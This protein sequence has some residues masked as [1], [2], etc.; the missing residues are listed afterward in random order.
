MNLTMIRSTGQNGY[1]R[2][3]AAGLIN[4]IGARFSQVAMLSLVLKLTGSGMAV[5]L[6][7]GLSLLPNLLFAPLGGFLGGRLSRRRILIATDLAR[8][9]FALS[10]LL[11]DGKGMLWLLYAGSFMLA[12]GEAVYAPVRKSAI[13]LLARPGTLQRVNAMEQLMTGC[14]LVLGALTGGLV[15]YWF[16]PDTAFVLNALSF[17]G[18]AVI[19]SGISFPGEAGDDDSTE[20]GLRQASGSGTGGLTR[21]KGLTALLAGSVVLQV[22]IGYEIMVSMVSGLDNVLISVYAI[23]VFHKGDAGVGAFYASLGAGLTLSFWASR[24]LKGNLL[25]AA[26]GGLLIEGLVLAGISMSRSFIAVCGLYVLLSLASGISNASLDTLLMR[27]TPARWQPSVF[28]AL[29]AG[30]NTLLGLSMLLAGWLLEWVEP[31][32]LGFTGGVCFAGIALFLGAYA[33]IRSGKSRKLKAPPELYR[34]GQH[35]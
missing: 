23:E 30:G 32:T 6:S 14:V 4:G 16:G 35:R 1:Y 19:I 26:L 9:P 7:L 12:A 34:P 3:F 25:A 21:R 31:R 24:R 27:E 22:L 2:L 11:V 17:L 28:G 5:G 20:S 8:V 10:F 33:W 18:A 13:P 29:A 15:S